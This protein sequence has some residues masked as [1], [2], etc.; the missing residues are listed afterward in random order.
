MKQAGAGNG[1]SLTGEQA[2]NINAN[3]WYDF[4]LHVYSYA[5]SLFCYV[6]VL[7][8]CASI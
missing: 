4:I 2:Q 8:F 6:M 5:A 7:S 1:K 3:V